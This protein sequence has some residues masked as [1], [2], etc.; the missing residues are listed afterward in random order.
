MR[1]LA[2]A[3]VIGLLMMIGAPPV[4]VGR[5]TPA[6]GWGRVRLAVAGDST[7]GTDTY[8]RKVRVDV[9]EWWR[10]AA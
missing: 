4:A 7:A 10:K 3:I 9:R 5:S 6:L 1:F 8:A 2:V